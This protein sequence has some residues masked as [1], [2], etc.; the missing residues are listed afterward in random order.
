M[1]H[2]T[3]RSCHA[4]CLSMLSDSRCSRTRQGGWRPS[5]VIQG[6]VYHCVGPL[7]AAEGQKRAFAQLYVHDPA[8][9]DDEAA[10][11][12]SHMRLPADMSKPQKQRALELLTELQD[13]LRETNT[14]VQDF[15]SA[16]ELLL[17]VH[18][19]GGDD[20]GTVG[21]G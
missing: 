12:F 7:T 1:S 8:A 6:K 15:V 4:L 9:V 21:F 2:R 18:A 5:V 11:R 14:Y 13:A 19:G 10:T 17:H 3:K 16:G 20:G